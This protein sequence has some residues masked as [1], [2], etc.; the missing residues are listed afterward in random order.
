MGEMYECSGVA[1]GGT[2]ENVPPP[3]NSGKFSKN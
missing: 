1:S 2:G 3:R